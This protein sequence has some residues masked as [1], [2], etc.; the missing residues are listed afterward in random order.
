MS[1]ALAETLLKERVITA[2]QYAEAVDAHKSKGQCYI[3]FLIAKKYL[4]DAK[5]AQYLSQKFGLPLVNASK[6][7]VSPEIVKL[8]PL[9][10]AK[11]Y[12]IVPL[13]QTKN[14]LIC[15]VADPTQLVH[16]EEIKFR[17]KLN[18]EAVLCSFSALDA[19][20]SKLYNVSTVMASAMESFASEISLSG[21]TFEVDRQQAIQVDENSSADDAPIITL[22]NNILLEGIKRGASDIHVECYEK[23]CRVRMRID[24]YL[25][26]VLQIPPQMRRP[27][28]ARFKIISKMDIAES[29]IPQ[30]DRKS[31]V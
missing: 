28:L 9:E 19:A 16:L 11:K 4:S 7:E 18:V 21:E 26:E 27:V 20:L 24:G 17:T 13:Q 22:V 29:R 2:Q 25:Q 14:T 30:E 10:L 15:A 23:R 31:V 12:N 6:Y 1:K 5:L 3:R 8:I